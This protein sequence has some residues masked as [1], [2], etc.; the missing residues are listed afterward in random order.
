M[1]LVVKHFYAST[2]PNAEGHYVEIAARQSGVWAWILA[3][4]KIDPTFLMQVSYNE[5]VYQATTLAGYRKTLI[6]TGSVSSSFYGYHKPIKEALI[7][8]GVFLLMGYG[9]AKGDSFLAAVL[10]VL[11]GVVVAGVYYFLN[12][13]LSIG[14]SEING[15]D[16][17]MLIKRSVIENT[18]INEEQMKLVADIISTVLRENRNI[19]NA[20]ASGAPVHNS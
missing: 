1:T 13:K 16:Y 12:K 17:G 19:G 20:A 6:T 7:L 9:A 3:L 4:L 8:L 15:D 14:F 2:T 10:L 11:I 18:E 5:I